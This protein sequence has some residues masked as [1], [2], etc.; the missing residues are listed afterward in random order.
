MGTF[1][2]VSTDQLDSW[3]ALFGLNANKLIMI[4]I[5]LATAMA[6]TAIPLLSGAHARKKTFQ[7]SQHI[8]MTR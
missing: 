5:S 4:T 6:V 2:K 7:K 3:Y 8:L 1:V